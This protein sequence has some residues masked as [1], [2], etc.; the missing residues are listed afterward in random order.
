M[1]PTSCG[2]A[3]GEVAGVEFPFGAVPRVAHTG[4]VTA[5]PAAPA[6][7][8]YSLAGRV[9]G[10]VLGAIALVCGAAG[11]LLT[12][13]FLARGLADAS[14]AAAPWK[15]LAAT[16]L[17]LTFTALFAALGMMGWR[18]VVAGIRGHA[19]AAAATSQDIDSRRLLVSARTR[20][21]LAAFV[22]GTLVCA[23]TLAV[24]GGAAAW[25]AFILFGAAVALGAVLATARTPESSCSFCGAP[26]AKATWLVAGQSAS[27]CDRCIQAALAEF[28]KHF[29]SRGETSDWCN[30]F[31][32]ALP[33]HCPRAISRP[34]I[35]RL[36][37]QEWTAAEIR[38]AV[39][40]C[41][42][43]GNEP[44][45][46]HLLELIPEPE[47]H[48]EDWLNLGV[49]LGEEG[50][51]EDALEA[52][53]RAL[54]GGDERLRP[55]VLNNSAWFRSRLLPDAMADERAAWL[56]DVEE[57]ERLIGARRQAD[58]ERLMPYLRG[59]KAE[60]RRLSGDLEG[61]IQVIERA[62]AEQPLTGAQLFIRAQALAALGRHAE[63]RE[64]LER[65]L[66]LLHPEERMADEARRLLTTFA[67]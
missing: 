14:L 40:W 2:R 59:T 12:A 16:V 30:R 7:R 23:F 32:G 5:P 67:S 52:T 51:F 54:P 45:A 28:A 17:V 31:L 50:R 10:I 15:A 18:R 34:F 64:S 8:P 43:L 4:P 57:A 13:A 37:G 63:A 48:P 42:K 11:A 66:S 58:R 21:F 22:V 61:A 38:N 6:C 65:A 35:E 56:R 3:G 41:F 49:A 29:A 60:L 26:R 55:W 36:A 46:R 19:A 25:K 47:R 9:V 1:T 33:S 39:G 53:K 27:I 44:F 20:R 62:A 24:V